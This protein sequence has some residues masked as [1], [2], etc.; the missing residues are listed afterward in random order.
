MHAAANVNVTN[1][2]ASPPVAEPQSCAFAAPFPTPR[3]PPASGKRCVVRPM[4][5]QRRGH[6]P[7][8]SLSASSGNSAR[9]SPAQQDSAAAELDEVDGGAVARPR[10][11]SPHC[12]VVSGRYPSDV[13]DAAHGPTYRPHSP[14]S[15]ADGG[16]YEG[17]AV[18]EEALVESGLGAGSVAVT[19]PTRPT[20]PQMSPLS[21][22]HSRTAPDTR[23]E[24]GG[25]G[26]AAVAVAAQTAAARPAVT[27]SLATCT[28]ELSFSMAPNS[29]ASSSFYG[30]LAGPPPRRGQAAAPYLTSTPAPPVAGAEGKAVPLLLRTALSTPTIADDAATPTTS[31]SVSRF[32]SSGAALPGPHP[33]LGALLPSGPTSIGS[34]TPVSSNRSSAH[35]SF[36]R[37]AGSLRG[38]PPAPGPASVG[39]AV[40]G[41]VLGS[42]LGARRPDLGTR[43][44]TFQRSTSSM[45]LSDANAGRAAP[46]SGH[47]T[48]ESSDGAAVR[49]PQRRPSATLPAEMR[50]FV[51]GQYRTLQREV[52]A[53]PAPVLEV[54]D[55][56]APDFQH[57]R[58][59]TCPV[60][61][62]AAKR[63]R[64]KAEEEGRLRVLQQQH[65][66]L[67]VI[68][69]GGREQVGQN[70]KSSFVLAGSLSKLRARTRPVLG[71][72]SGATDRSRTSMELSMSG[73]EVL[74]GS[75]AASFLGSPDEHNATALYGGSVTPERGSDEAAPLQSPGGGGAEAW[76]ASKAFMPAT[77]GRGASQRPQSARNVN[78]NG[79]KGEAIVVAVLPDSDDDEGGTTTACPTR[80]NCAVAAAK[81]D[82]GAAAKQA[83]ERLASQPQR[84]PSSAAPALGRRPRGG[85]DSTSSDDETC[86]SFN[87][88]RSRRVGNA[89]SLSSTQPLD[90]AAPAAAPRTAQ[91]SDAAALSPDAPSRSHSRATTA[92]LPDCDSSDS[93]DAGTSESCCHCCPCRR[94]EN[95]LALCR[96]SSHS[97]TSQVWP[98]RSDAVGDAVDEAAAPT[99]PQPG[100][101]ATSAAG[102]EATPIGGSAPVEVEDL[103]MSD[104]DDEPT[105]SMQSF[106]RASIQRVR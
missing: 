34:V 19:S 97:A 57:I 102:R 95:F 12:T 52:A 47:V 7:N 42:P 92:L 1:A 46:L 55:V 10:R 9:K 64:L 72:G 69:N 48:D 39:H 71:S 56:S 101:S 51:L 53:Q 33:P 5:L 13:G 45:S 35:P 85:G 29:S 38:G 93:D 50:S 60:H 23:G 105:L 26:A 88:H 41:R 94:P 74:A 77:G 20:A 67:E 68:R 37:S 79:M 100:R 21:A 82:S 76:H 80:G 32:L 58:V 86:F 44:T 84:R 91:C 61:S 75:P 89:P 54:V 14:P 87:T 59:A 98:D 70:M 104:D 15:S 83:G 43:R 62:K 49:G 81:R 65:H 66:D 17:A 27:P 22:S 106:R 3:T 99:A 18:D 78:K 30:T 11:P 63:A 40:N 16:R 2:S 4:L 24:A 96:T 6:T 73:T 103:E 36:V 25:G 31:R 28:S 90:T 8:G